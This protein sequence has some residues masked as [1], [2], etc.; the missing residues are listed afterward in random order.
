MTDDERKT[1]ME[2]L[3]NNRSES[4]G[5]L[6]ELYTNLLTEM[7]EA[8]EIARSIANTVDPTE[9]G[10]AELQNLLVIMDGQF[11]RKAQAVIQKYEYQKSLENQ[12]EVE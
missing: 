5:I 2:N 12:E 7:G 3:N 8:I 4:D 10:V 6:A 9:E 1:K 11:L